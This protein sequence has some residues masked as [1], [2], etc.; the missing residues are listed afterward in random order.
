ML[1]AKRKNAHNDGP[2]EVKATDLRFKL[3]AKV[4]N[5]CEKLKRHKADHSV[6]PSEQTIPYQRHT[7]DLRARLN[8]T[9]AER[10][11][12]SDKER[13]ERPL[14]LNVIMGGSPPCDD[15]VQSVK[16]TTNY[17]NTLGRPKPYLC[18]F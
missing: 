10:W 4:P 9:K 16:E 15:S 3:N 14:H 8:R 12:R 6:A 7:P 5:L 2:D 11:T 18:V 13:L 17:Q 1:E